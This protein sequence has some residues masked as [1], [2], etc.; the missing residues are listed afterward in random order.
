[1]IPKESFPIRLAI[2]GLALIAAGCGHDTAN[3]GLAPG[4][5]DPL[6]F[7]DN[8]GAGIDYQAFRGSKS[9]VLSVDK[10]QMHT[11][12]ASLKV[13]V[14]G[15]S[16]PAGAYAG[17]AMTCA[18]PR[19]PSGY[20]A[21]SFWARASK[22]ATLDVAG[23]GND[24]TGE[25]K[26]Q[27]SWANIPLTTE[28]K[29]YVIP[30]PLTGKM[31]AEKGMF[32]FAEGP[33]GGSGYTLWFDDIMFE[34]LDTITNPRPGMQSRTAG[35]F[36]GSRYVVQGTRTTFNVGGTDQVVE[37]FPAYFTFSSSD[38][39]VARPGDGF[40]QVVGP[41]T[42]TLTAS[43]GTV[44]AVGTVTL[45]STNVPPAA[46]PTPTLP[47]GNVI[48]LFSNAYSSVPVDTWSA[49]WDVADV[50]DLKIAGN[51]TKA[52]T[53]LVY[54]GIEFTTH[55]IDA[56]GMTHFHLDVWTESGSIFR[57]K[58]VDFGADGVYGGG[59]DREQELSFNG[60]TTPP[61]TVGRW[62]NLDIPLADFTALTT[63]AHIAQLIIEGDP[64]TAF[65]DNVY[66][67]N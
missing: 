41:G 2:V 66:F 16:D 9:N 12:T 45:I 58:L 52:Y 63:R 4:N 3:L 19:D 13:T 54:A 67:H 24:N 34:N 49:S 59:D 60:G 18:Q 56:T 42:T 30:I 57:V 5:T 65:L 39:L 61:L 47:A 50:S 21:L 15:P 62:S 51:D 33:E 55:P 48:S 64:G 38:E 8:F 23:V 53:N 17:G 36:V 29:K 11:G 7:T 25:S 46:A 32:F 1:V 37:H 26:Y 14:P 44:S 22:V 6:V 10:T 20:N 43:L 35:A 28:W 31:R 27:A 40:I